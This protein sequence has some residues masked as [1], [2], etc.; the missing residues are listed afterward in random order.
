MFLYLWITLVKILGP[1]EIFSG[2]SGLGLSH[3]IPAD[4]ILSLIKRNDHH[5]IAYY[6]LLWLNAVARG[7]T[8]QFNFSLRTSFSAKIIICFISHTNFVS[9]YPF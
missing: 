2:I 6:V 8:P 1:Y 9:R 7:Q 5:R 3:K 4:E